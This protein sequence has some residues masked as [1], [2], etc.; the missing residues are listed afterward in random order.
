MAEIKAARFNDYSFLD[1]DDF[2]RAY[3]NRGRIRFYVD[4]ISCG[5]CVRKIEDLALTVKGLEDLR[6]DLA[7]HTAE[8][9]VDPNHLEFSELANHIQ[10]LGFNPIPLKP[11]DS[12]EQ[13]Q[14]L[15]DRHELIRLAVAAACA[16]NIMTFSFATY[17][18]A[19]ADF[20][21]VFSWLSFALYLPVVF[22]VAIPF[23]RGAWYSLARKQISIDLPMA[24]ASFSGFIFSTIEL[25]RGKGD[26]Y[27]DS[28]SGFLFLI[29]LSRYAQ[30]RLQRRFIRPEE[31]SETL[32]L[33]RVRQVNESGWSWTRTENT[34]IGERIL[35]QA[36][37]TLPADAELISSTAHFSLAWLS[38]ESRPKTFLRGA[39][40]PAGALLI[41][42]EAQLAIRKPL[43]DTSFGKI[44]KSVE[45]QS[46]GGTRIANLADRSAQ[47]LLATVFT[48]AIVFLVGY[49]AVSPEEAVRRALALIILACPCAMAFGTPLALAASL[50]KARKKG[51]I[52]RNADVFEKA[53]SVKTIFFDKT[54]TLTDS[55]L[56]LTTPLSQIALVHQKVILALENE[57]LHPIAFAFRRAF[58]EE[59]SLPPVDGWRESVGLGVSGFVYGKF[60]EV[61][62][63]SKPGTQVSCTL[64][65]DGQPI[66]DCVFS[67]I[68][69]PG[70]RAALDTLR[71]EGIQVALLSGDAKEVTE[72]IGA[73]LGFTQTEIL[74]ECCPAV[75]A[76]E[77]ARTPHAMMVGD[78]V[79]DSLAMLRADVGVA[80][81][82]GMATALKAADVYL[83]NPSLEGIQALIR[84]SRE[85]M[86]L[87]RRNLAISVLYNLIG[88]SLAVMGFINPFV[89]ALLMPISSAFILLSTYIA[90][91]RP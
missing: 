26:I 25:I 16:G 49:W 21:S 19:S 1:Q 88:G 23:Y 27:F 73:Q 77:V 67:S 56:T 61:K 71:G 38:G 59:H 46:V 29:L 50:K 70:S 84:I 76:T 82:G 9:Q 5:K 36:K 68:L 51:L 3:S 42:G 22:Y 69:K 53:A 15:S 2:R 48:L 18:G 85:G 80:V 57:S 90:E 54:G 75:K 74:Y 89:A 87:I 33:S 13:L 65:E 86:A 43:L 10:R 32:Q 64:F 91:R 58:N 20:A 39:I 8:A 45:E 55:D 31:L 47:W 35:L 78:G 60:Y 30:R 72:N 81:S 52:V 63:N 41:N 14:R 83:A 40:V 34:R 4:G 28:L 7:S 37:E 11:E 12:A 62:R 66:L 6:V 79:N 17:L 24:V 44:L